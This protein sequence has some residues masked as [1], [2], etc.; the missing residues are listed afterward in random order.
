[1]QMP[2]TSA[3]LALVEDDA[4]VRKAILRLL[5]VAGFSAAG[6][7]SAEA[8]LESGPMKQV[9]CVIIDIN[10]PGLSGFELQEKLI[11][12]GSWPVIFITAHDEPSV[13]AKYQQSGAVAYLVKPFPSE[14]LISAIRTAL[15][16]I[17]QPVGSNPTRVDGR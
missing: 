14:E 4:S 17:P 9:D 11:A 8:F 10:L 12:T 3:N 13:R 7:G 1:M 16:V 6:F 15:C 2:Q 5:S